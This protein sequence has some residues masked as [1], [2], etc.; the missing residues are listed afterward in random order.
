MDEK[1]VVGDFVEV[2]FRDYRTTGEVLKV[3][4]FTIRV[5][6]RWAGKALE[7]KRHIIKHRVVLAD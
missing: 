1:I 5:K 3:N 6:I 2:D 7:I 4:D